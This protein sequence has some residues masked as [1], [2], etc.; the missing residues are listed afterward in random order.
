MS[1][2]VGESPYLK[3]SL[4]LIMSETEET[5]VFEVQLPRWRNRV[6]VCQEPENKGY[7]FTLRIDRLGFVKD[8]K[9][10]L[11]IDIL[12]RYQIL[13]RFLLND[14]YSRLEYNI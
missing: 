6:H 13:L 5:N 9:R 8:C 12:T 2:T 1:A 4:G 7:V 11:G 10:R 14:L 3:R